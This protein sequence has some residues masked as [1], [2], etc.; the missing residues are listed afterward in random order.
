MKYAYE[1]F[2]NRM[3]AAIASCER[4]RNEDVVLLPEPG[5]VNGDLIPHTSEI[6][7]CKSD[8]ASDMSR[9][10]QFV[11][12]CKMEAFKRVDRESLSQMAAEGGA[13]N[14]SSG[15]FEDPGA[16]PTVQPDASVLCADGRPFSGNDWLCNRQVSETAAP[17]TAAKPTAGIG[18]SSPA[19]AARNDPKPAAASASRSGPGQAEVDADLNQCRGTLQYAGVC[20]GSPMSCAGDLSSANQE[21]LKVL[22]SSQAED[23]G[24][25]GS[26]S[27]MAQL[28]SMNR[29]VN[30]GFASICAVRQQSCSDTCGQLAKKYENLLSTCG[31]NCEQNQLYQSAASSLAGRK[32]SCDGLQAKAT[33]LISQS[34]SNQA[35]SDASAPAMDFSSIALDPETETQKVKKE[36][37]DL[38]SENP[39][40]PECLAVPVPPLTQSGEGT[41]AAVKK[42]INEN[43]F[44]VAEAL[45][46]DAY[47]P[48]VTPPSQPP[49]VTAPPN[50][51]G[52]SIPQTT[53][54]AGSAPKRKGSTFFSASNGK[55][56]DIFPGGYMSGGYSAPYQAASDID[57]TRYKIRARP[58]AKRKGDFNSYVGLDLKRYLPGAK[59][60]PN[61]RLAGVGLGSREINGKSADLWKKITDKVTERCRLGLLWKCQP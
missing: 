16:T 12:E 55:V 33:N 13:Q 59:L 47:V 34:L 15:T 35:D 54:T 8:L 2:N 22:S 18:S 52:G 48:S 6:D 41:Y 27:Q 44:N 37:Q 56:T 4:L 9:A 14:V 42:S 5:V 57:G 19:T 46:N 60:D 20:C 49:T 7:K 43:D 29:D 51:T 32:A 61:R 25:S 39:Q 45:T 26:A 30:A 50:N 24:M 11:S 17:A 31:E 10:E 23:S 58:A 1:C 28:T 38:C 21:K 53:S 36:T 40:S 3:N